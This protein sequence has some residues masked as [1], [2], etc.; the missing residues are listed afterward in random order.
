MNL[1]FSQVLE[2]FKKK[3][4]ENSFNQFSDSLSENIPSVIAMKSSKNFIPCYQP[5]MFNGKDLY[6]PLIAP[7][8]VLCLE[9]K[10][11]E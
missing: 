3:R 6:Y 8:S 1:T 9:M 10:V 2:N 11:I 5:V 4:K 7:V